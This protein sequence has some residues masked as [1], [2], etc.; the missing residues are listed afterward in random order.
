MA[1]S[2]PIIS[3]IKSLLQLLF[4]QSNRALETQINFID[5]TPLLSQLKSLY[6]L[7]INVSPIQAYQTQKKFLII[8]NATIESIPVIGH[9]KGLGH[10]LIGDINRGNIAMKRSSRTTVV[11]LSAY[12]ACIVFV[13]TTA[14]LSTTITTS[15]IG[16][17]IGGISMDTL[18]TIIENII[19][20]NGSLNGHYKSFDLMVKNPSDVGNIFDFLIG[21][22]LDA[23]IGAVVGYKMYQF[24]NISL[25]PNINTIDTLPPPPKIPALSSFA[26][27]KNTIPLP[28]PFNPLMPPISTQN[29][30]IYGTVA[31]RCQL[32]T[33]SKYTNSNDNYSNYSESDYSSSVSS[34]QI[35]NSELEEK[36]LKDS[37]FKLSE[38]IVDI[39]LIK[40]LTSDAAFIECEKILSLLNSDVSN[41]VIIDVRQKNEDYIGGHIANSIRI[42]H[43]TFYWQIPFI[44]AQYNSKSMFILQCM[45]GVRRSVECMEF[46]AKAVAEVIANYE[47]T[48]ETSYFIMY[49]S[50]I[51]NDDSGSKTKFGAMNDMNNSIYIDKKI[52]YIKCTESMYNNLCNQ[53]LYVVKDG[54]F[55]LI[56]DPNVD[57]TNTNIIAEFDEDEWQQLSILNKTKL[58]HKN[59]FFSSDNF[60]EIP[61][62]TTHVA[63]ISVT[64]Q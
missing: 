13:P 45:Y 12:F 6:E 23:L 2:I 1:D 15:S 60:N 16:S 53:K 35:N 17:I 9:I 36:E 44:F 49:K 7:F 3:Q 63:D 26:V 29:A 48:D 27:S 24:T 14:T 21:P 47:K 33:Q 8:T 40:D 39:N 52:I 37:E 54:F 25:Y 5:A 42:P 32:H 50:K 46:Y 28:P 51:D 55:G 30:M 61:I 11:I 41:Y 4:G 43:M 38:S 62:K 59:E 19:S 34:I 18:T 57:K 64:F 10:Y 20:K 31:A 58:Y 22:L 56:N